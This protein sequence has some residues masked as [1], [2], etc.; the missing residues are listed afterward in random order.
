MKTPG[1]DRDGGNRG[2][3]I[4]TASPYLSYSRYLRQ[5][6]GCDVYRVAVEQ[7]KNLLAQAD[8]LRA[9]LALAQKS[10]P[11]VRFA[12]PLPERCALAWSKSGST[13]RIRLQ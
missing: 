3:P 5:R 8:N 4:V 13:S 7:V 1:A 2:E 12:L 6:H 9:Q 11:T 10:W